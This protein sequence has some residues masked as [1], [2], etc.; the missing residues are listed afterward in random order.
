MM[1]V[2][3]QKIFFF[4]SSSFRLL[5]G[6]DEVFSPCHEK[7]RRLLTQT[8]TRNQGWSLIEDTNQDRVM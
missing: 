3:C 7:G 6:S 1:P 8:A 5:V 2:G 4:F